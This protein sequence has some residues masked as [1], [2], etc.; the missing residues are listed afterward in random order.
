M[1]WGGDPLTVT[2]PPE[3]ARLLR[4]SALCVFPNYRLAIIV[5]AVVVAIAPLAAARSH[6]A[7][8]HDPRRRRRSGHGA[9]GRHPGVAAVHD[10]V[11]A[12]RRAGGLRR[13]HRRADPLGLSG[14]R[15]GHA[16]AGAG[17]R[18]P[19]R[20]RQPARLASSAASSSASSTISA[21]RCCPSSPISSCSCRCCW[22]C[23]C[24]RRAC[25]AG[26]CHER[27]SRSPL[28]S[29]SLLLATLPYWVPGIYYVNVASQILF[30]AVFALGLNV[31][32]GY[33]GLVSLGHAGLFGVAAYAAALHAAARL[34]PSVGD[35]RG[36]GR[37]AWPRWRS[38]ARCR[39]A[40]PASASS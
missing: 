14:A 30:Y 26:T 3:L 29:P 39:C 9:R 38:C 4:V 2:R 36:A 8:R 18:H 6:P 35:P 11:R 23:S 15:S 1:V 7:R 22:S 16:A 33:A 40:R 25:S 17:R 21:R 31:L 5:I 28:P 24:G 32:V 10:R 37:S 20:H 34:R 12:G 19:R 27:A 13:H